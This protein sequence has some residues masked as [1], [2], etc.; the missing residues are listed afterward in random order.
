MMS[1]LN[2]RV[3]CQ[4]EG[5]DKLVQWAEAHGLPRKMAENPKDR[6]KVCRTFQSSQN[7]MY[8]AES[9]V[10]ALERHTHTHGH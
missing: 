5:W 6:A 8:D 4:E 10:P 9:A 3:V 7:N 1:R 2:A